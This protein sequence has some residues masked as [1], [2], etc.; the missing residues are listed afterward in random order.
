MKEAEQRI[1]RQEAKFARER[2][3]FK[4]QLHSAEARAATDLDLAKSKARMAAD[5]EKK[6]LRSLLTTAQTEVIQQKDEESDRL[7]AQLKASEGKD[8]AARL[9]QLG[10]T[11]K[12]ERSRQTLRRKSWG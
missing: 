11:C 5:R 2:S 1:A 3:A 6:E 10:A 4:D 8:T 12:A 9:K 7:R